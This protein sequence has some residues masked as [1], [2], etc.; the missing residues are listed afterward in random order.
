MLQEKYEKLRIND[1]PINIDSLRPWMSLGLLQGRVHPQWEIII[2]TLQQE[3]GT[4]PTAATIILLLHT[5]LETWYEAVW[6]PRCQRTIDQER[7]LG[8]HQS[9][10]LRRMREE[11]RSRMNAHPSPTPN[12]P[13]SQ[14]SGQERGTAYDQFNSELMNGTNN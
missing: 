6:L 11:N 14:L 9:T 10:K 13:H 5:S 4:T 3:Q 7:R 8:L 2:P 1:T 12:L